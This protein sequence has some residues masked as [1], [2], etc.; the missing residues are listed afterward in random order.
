M[1]NLRRGRAAVNVNAT[2]IFRERQI[3]SGV[4]NLQY[5]TADYWHL[6]TFAN[7]TS[8]L[9]ELQLQSD[10]CVYMKMSR[11]NLFGCFQSATTPF[12]ERWASEC[13]TED[14]ALLAESSCTITVVSIL[15]LDNH[16][17]KTPASRGQAPQRSL[18][19]G[20]MMLYIKRKVRASLGIFD[21]R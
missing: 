21:G 5:S 18:S 13:A 17:S 10:P 3:T 19:R 6:W 20:K 1:K 9:N 14:S 16:S 12:M 4:L 8:R 7:M 2:L 11:E 15:V